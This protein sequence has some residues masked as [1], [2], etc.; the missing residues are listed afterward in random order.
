MPAPD[1][2]LI[3]YYENIYMKSA[4]QIKIDWTFHTADFLCSSVGLLKL[5]DAIFSPVSGQ[6]F[7]LSSFANLFYSIISNFSVLI[8]VSNFSPCP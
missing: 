5:D 7:N 4:I 8:S 1:V 6:N 2:D 3:N